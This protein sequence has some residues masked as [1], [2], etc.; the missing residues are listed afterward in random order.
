MDLAGLKGVIKNGKLTH[1]TINVFKALERLLLRS[2]SA[3]F[4]IVDYWSVIV[5]RAHTSVITM[6]T[7]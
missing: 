1:K 2:C 3:D 7:Q 5:G 4:E 6:S